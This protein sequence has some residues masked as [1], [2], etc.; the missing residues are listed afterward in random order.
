MQAS[1]PPENGDITGFSQSETILLFERALSATANK[2]R[3][4]GESAGSKGGAGSRGYPHPS[5]VITGLARIAVYSARPRFARSPRPRRTARAFC[6]R[7][8]NAPVN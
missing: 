3:N 5:F 6:F 4:E 7:M 2:R 8:L 1:R